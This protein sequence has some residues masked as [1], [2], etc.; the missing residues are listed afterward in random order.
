MFDPRVTEGLSST[1]SSSLAARSVV[2]PSS[3]Q[4]IG[5]ERSSEVEHGCPNKL[6][7]R[8]RLSHHWPGVSTQSTYN[9]VSRLRPHLVL[10]IPPL[11]QLIMRCELSAKAPAAEKQTICPRCSGKRHRRSGSK[12]LPSARFMG[13]ESKDKLQPSP[14]NRYGCGGGGPPGSSTGLGPSLS[15]RK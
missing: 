8:R 7:G 9:S 5:E 12:C 15:P 14:A 1:F 10:E 6:G 11:I 2:Q 4:R 13:Q 3:E